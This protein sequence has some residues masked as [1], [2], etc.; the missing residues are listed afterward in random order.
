MAKVILYDEKGKAHG[1]YTDT[2]IAH[3][4]NDTHF[5]GRGF[6]SGEVEENTFSESP[7]L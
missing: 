4:D 7:I 5:R 2:K 6:V 1:V 3:R